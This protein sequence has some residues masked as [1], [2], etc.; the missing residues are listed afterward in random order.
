MFTEF[1]SVAGK[2]KLWKYS[3]KYFDKYF[4]NL[5]YSV[6]LENVHWNIF[7]EHFKVW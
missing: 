4:R 5:T 2:V 3:S 1:Q 7:S 6:I